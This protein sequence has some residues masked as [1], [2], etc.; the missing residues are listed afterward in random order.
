MEKDKINIINIRHV[1]KVEGHAELY[2]EIQKQKVSQVNLKI[3]EGA[4]MFESIIRGYYYYDIPQMVSRICG[5]CSASHL[6]ASIYA[7]EDAITQSMHTDADDAAATMSAKFSISDQTKTLRYLLHSAEILQSH[8][9][10]LYFMVLP[11]YLGFSSALD[12]AKHPKYKKYLLDALSLKKLSQDILN[13]FSGREVNGMTATI[14]GFTRLPS[15]QDVEKIKKEIKKCYELVNATPELFASFSYE[16]IYHQRKHLAC[17]DNK[18]YAFY[19]DYFVDE[20]LTKFD[21]H[22]YLNHLTEFVKPGS[23]A[24]RSKFDDTLYF[25]GALSRIR[26]NKPKILSY[27]SSCFLPSDTKKELFSKNINPYYNNIAQA[28]EVKIIVDNILNILDSFTE[29]SNKETVTFNQIRALLNKL[30]NKDVHGIGI[31]EAPRGL[32][33]HD[34]YFKS[35]KLIKANIITPTAMNLL[36]IEQDIK[37]LV[38]ADLFSGNQTQNLEIEKLI[39]AY[40][41]CISCSAHFLKINW[42]YKN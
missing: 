27:L 11:D 18:Q 38:E 42:K 17:Y 8:I 6:L 30:K 35:G 5:I 9:M 1:T 7:I 24:K 28:I 10:H 37:N 21:K 14:S 4:R 23:T 3:T 39:R 41:P 29:F 19:S 2:V 40:D 15:V 34:Y 31:A 16:Q 20:N 32:L 33:I 13:I 26:I 25:V 36:S 12:M 22:N